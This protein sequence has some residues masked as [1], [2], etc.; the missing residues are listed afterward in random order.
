MML[1][2]YL[3]V[4]CWLKKHKITHLKNSHGVSWQVKGC[5]CVSLDLTDS[6]D[7]QPQECQS[8][9]VLGAIFLLLF[10]NLF[11]KSIFLV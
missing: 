3:H 10:I 6:G 11:Y 5:L 9:F 1:G 7:L 4:F 8:S 2:S